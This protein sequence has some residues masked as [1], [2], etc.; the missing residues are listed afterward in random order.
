MRNDKI[1]AKE[2]FNQAERYYD[3]AKEILKKVK[4]T[5]RTYDD[6]KYVSEACGTVYL[7]MLKA[8]DGYLILQGV[9]KEKLPDTYQGYVSALKR[10]L[11]HNGKIKSALTEVYQNLHVYGYYRE[12]V[13]VGMIKLGLESAKFI[14]NYFSKSAE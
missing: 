1:I 7:S 8:L 2:Y 14:I 12:G 6:S 3:N 4:I 10:K 13:S 9:E 5:Y 11:A